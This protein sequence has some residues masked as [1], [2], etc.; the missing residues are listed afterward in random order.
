MLQF[1]DLHNHL[2]CGVDDGAK[3]PEEM[4]QMLEDAYEDGIRA[5]CLT[6]HQSP[7]L[8]GD[9]SSRARES[10]ALLE[11]YVA[12]KYPDMR[13]FLGSELGYYHRALEDLDAGRCPTMNG[14]RYVLVDFPETVELFTIQNA[15]STLM[16]GGYLM[17]LAHAERYQCL[18]KDTAWLE[19]F[20]DEGG[21]I[22]LN[23]SSCT[24][25]W[26]K[27]VRRQWKKL[28][29]RGLVHIISSDGHNTTSRPPL[30]SVCMPFLRKHCD[31]QT[32]IDLVWN[33]ACR[34]M[35]DER[36]E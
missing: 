32:L 3:S 12:Q 24:G 17:I 15:A 22:Q 9:T 5:I 20:A 25:S 29:R 30:I 7:Y 31:E 16:R 35:R 33:N 11:E 8:Y 6:P 28:V 21:V 26:G 13:L 36:I 4:Y 2:L 10:F 1:F 34:V 18:M 23:A 19:A 14:S 27:S